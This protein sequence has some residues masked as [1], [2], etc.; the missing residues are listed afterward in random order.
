MKD[1]RKSADVPILM[2]T[3]CLMALL[4]AY[5]A[6]YFALAKDHRD[7][8]GAPVR[9]FPNKATATFYVPAVWLESYLSDVTYAVGWITR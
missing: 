5:A 8:L 9:L 7:S 6:G 4:G 2:A 3:L 1:E